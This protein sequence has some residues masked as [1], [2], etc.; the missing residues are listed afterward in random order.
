MIWLRRLLAVFLGLILV[1]LFFVSLVVLR[2][3]DTLLNPQVYKDQLQKENI[4]AFLI[5]DVVPVVIEENWDDIPQPPLGVTVDRQK[6]TEAVQRV[7]TPEWLQAQTEQVLDELLPYV[8]GQS[9]SFSITI[10]LASR[11]EA[12]V[13]EIKT[14]L[15]NSNLYNTV[16]DQEFVDTVDRELTAMSGLPF[17]LAFSSQDLV[18]AIN[19]VAPTEWLKLQTEQAIDDVI[20]YL[21][22]ETDQF[23]VQIQVKDRVDI[24]IPVLKDLLR[25]TYVYNLVLDQAVLTLIEENVGEIAGLPLG[26]T[27]TKRR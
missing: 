19:Q 9:N 18:S 25:S 2:V 12:A 5:Q 24:A 14:L 10:P 13:P 20:P 17:E 3:N 11:V 26:I 21:I 27:I 8:T 15:A 23:D 6:I 16:S 4:Y 7:A 1:L 22:R